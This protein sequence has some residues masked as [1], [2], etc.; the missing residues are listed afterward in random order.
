MGPNLTY[1]L[2]HSKG[3]HKQKCKDNPQNGRKYL[4]MMDWQRANLQNIQ[5]IPTVQYQNNKQPNQ[6][7]ARLNR[8]FSKEH[9]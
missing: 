1:M 3:N 8:H 4:Q 6:K 5:T 7:W 2:L 9:I